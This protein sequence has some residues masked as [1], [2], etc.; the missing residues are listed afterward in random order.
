VTTRVR[1]GGWL[2]T[3]VLASASASGC[4]KVWS[5]GDLPSCAPQAKAFST[6]WVPPV[7]NARQCTFPQISQYFDACE[8]PAAMGTDCTAWT[9]DT[10]NAAC[11]ACLSTDST[12][13]AYGALITF[14][15]LQFL[16]IGGCIA[17]AN[18]ANPADQACAAAVLAQ[19]ECQTE[20]CDARPGANCAVAPGA[21]LDAY[22]SCTELAVACPTGG[23]VCSAYD[24]AVGKCL[25][26]LSS[27]ATVACGLGPGGGSTFQALYTTIATFMCAP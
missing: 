12:A 8:S 2:V 21:S 23:C 14:S 16:N 26:Q 15:G 10:A 18:P 7:A 22:R 6:P 5:I 24:D 20:A 17:L 19:T 3:A 11:Y 4:E 13:M 27:A 1:E 9:H 25:G